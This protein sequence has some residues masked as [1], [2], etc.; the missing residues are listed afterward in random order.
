MKQKRFLITWILTMAFSLSMIVP[1]NTSVSAQAAAKLKL[2]KTTV[3]L[4]EGKRTKLTLKNAGKKKIVWS[5]SDKKIAKVSQKGSVLAV[6]AGKATIK[7][8]IKGTKTSVSCKVVVGKY[9]TKLKLNSAQNVILKE[10]KSTKIKISVSPSKVLTKEVTYKSANPEIATVNSSGKITAVKQG[11]TEITVKTK[12]K[13]KKG[14]KLVQKISVYVEPIFEEEVE[15]K[16]TENETTNGTT[17]ENT[18]NNTESNENDTNIGSSTGGSGGTTGGGST[19]SS[20]GNSNSNS[21]SNSSQEKPIVDTII[22]G[23]KEIYILNKSYENQ[24][25]VRVTINGKSWNKATTVTS[26]L[27]SLENSYTTKENSEKTLR[28]SRGIED[29]W[30]IVTDL[31]TNTILFR[32]KAEPTYQGDKNKGQIV[33]EKISGTVNIQV[34]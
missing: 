24:V 19:S 21:N 17:E 27:S 14:K 30:W 31:T 8:T 20:N 25:T 6:K 2:N 28:V 29:E 9:A 3:S 16:E 7:A 15:D 1:I 12:A 11:L 5:T 34:Y 23:N 26:A 22:D 4:Y 33:V 32:I 18:G 13:N 10:G